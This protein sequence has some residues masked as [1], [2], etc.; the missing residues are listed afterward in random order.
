MTN[1][2]K[3]AFIGREAGKATIS[4]DYSEDDLILT[5]WD[6]GVGMSN[7]IVHHKKYGFGLSIIKMMVEQLDGLFEIVRDNGTKV[8]IVI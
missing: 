8:I 3:Y 1:I 5:V 6:N 2:F 4:L 7:E